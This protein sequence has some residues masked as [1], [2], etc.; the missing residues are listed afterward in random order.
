MAEWHCS[1]S[2]S[3]R[4]TPCAVLVV[5]YPLVMT[6]PMLIQ[7][8]HNPAS[9]NHDPA[10]IEALAAALEG[11]GFTIKTTH[12]SPV[13]PFA[14]LEEAAHVC[15]AGGDG[16]VRHVVSALVKAGRAPEFSIYPAGTI[17]LVAREWQ[18]PT[19][20]AAFAR[21]VAQ[22]GAARR[23]HPVA[24][25]DT[26]FVACLSI[27]PDARAVAAV[28]EPLKVKIGRLAYGVALLKVAL[29]WTRPALVVEVDGERIACEAAYVA[30]G[31]YFAGPWEFAP[32]A[33]LSSPDLHLV[34]LERARRR[35]FVA[36]LLR[37]LTG[38]VQEGGNIILRTCKALGIS[39][40]TGHPVQ[41]DGDIGPGLPLTLAITQPVLNG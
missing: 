16:T 6:K 12:S 24:L 33:R 36:F 28:S 27:G 25:N 4:L 7:L 41:V 40:P 14:L 22:D 19:G 30:K 26:H 34:L 29:N 9:G 20:P 15:V 13:H 17:N 21:H 35:D 5:P 23:L 18:A 8:V 38:R 2:S 31:R 32:D 11:Q 10:L 37:M 1:K 39:G 3:V